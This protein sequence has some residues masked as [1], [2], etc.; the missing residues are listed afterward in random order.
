MRKLTYKLDIMAETLCKK[1]F[2]QTIYQQLDEHKKKI[3]SKV[4]L[5]STK[6]AT[7]SEA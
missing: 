4:S 5:Y 2:I 7:G 3:S 6:L 1:N